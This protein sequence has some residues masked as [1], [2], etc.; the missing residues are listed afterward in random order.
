MPGTPHDALFKAT[1]SQVEHAAAALR[2]ILPPAVLARLDLKALALCPGSFVDR[3]LANR[4]TD[5]L[6]ST[7]LADRPALIYVLLEHQST[8]HPRMP[9]RLLGYMLRIWEAWLADHPDAPRLPP[10][11]PVV[12]HHSESGW[13][14]PIAFEDLLDVDPD[15][16]TAIRNYVPCFQFVLED[17][18]ISA[19][20]PTTPSE[21]AR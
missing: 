3:A 14:S 8:P 21:P 11:L 15:T 2:A 6:F 18:R 12:L 9:L 16:L 4:H 19:A 7:L 5:L 13:R 1:F 17:L 20:R 10:I